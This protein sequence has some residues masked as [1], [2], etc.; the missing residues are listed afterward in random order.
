MVADDLFSKYGPNTVFALLPVGLDARWDG[1]RLRVR[2]WPDVLHTTAH[3]PKLSPEEIDAGQAYWQAE[4]AAAGNDQ[5]RRAAWDEL[6]ER[7]GSGRA[8]WVALSLTPTN[9]GSG[10]PPVF[11]AVETR[12]EDTDPFVPTSEALPERFVL[13]GYLDGKQVFES[14]GEP[15]PKTLVTGLDTRPGEVAG[16]KNKEGDDLQLPAQMRWMSDFDEAK[17]LGLAFDLTIT[18][19]TR[20]DYLVVFGVRGGQ[21]EAA[22]GDLLNGHRF[23]RGLAFVPPGTPTNHAPGEPSGLPDAAARR[24]ISFRVERNK[25]EFSAPGDPADGRLLA[26]ALGF[27]STFFARAPNSGAVAAKIDEPQGFGVST[28]A[29]AVR[30]LWSVTLGGFLEDLV[31]AAPARVESVRTLAEDA[32]RP[33][34]PLPTL[35][36]GRQPYGVLPVLSFDHLAFATEDSVDPSLWGALVAARSVLRQAHASQTYDGT[37]ED[38]MRWLPRPEALAL[39]ALE[40]VPGGAQGNHFAQLAQLVASL[41]GNTL[42]DTWRSAAIN[43]VV[44]AN[45][46]AL[47]LPWV[48]ASLPASL[49]Q[50]STG[51]FFSFSPQVGSL[52]GRIIRQAGSLEWARFARTVIGTLADP[53]TTDKLQKM[54]D[55]P[56]SVGP[57]LWLLAL[58]TAFAGVPPSSLMGTPAAAA[59]KASPDPA[60]G[61]TA[62][63][64]PLLDPESAQLIRTTV[65]SFTIPNPASPGFDRLKRFRDTLTQLGAVPVAQIGAAL[66]DLIDL[67]HHRPDAWLTAIATRRLHTVRAEAPKGVVL[68]AWGLLQ[69]VKPRLR[70]PVEHFWAPSADQAATAAVLRAGGR[71]LGGTSLQ[72]DLPARRART[73]LAL[74]E[75]VRAGYAPAFLLGTATEARLF[76]HDALRHELR[77]QFPAAPAGAF[78]DGVALSTA[79]TAVLNA[80]RAAFPASVAAFNGAL[81]E[82]ANDVDAIADAL[83][84]ES[85]HRVA[86]GDASAGLFDLARLAEGTSPPTEL[87]SLET[88]VDA[89]ALLLRVGAVVPADAVSAWPTERSARAAADPHVEAWASALLGPPASWAITFGGSDGNG[90]SMNA[91]GFEIAALDLVFADADEL[92]ERARVSLGLAPAADL[93]F[94][95]DRSWLSL[96]GLCAAIRA[97]LSDARALGAHDLDRPGVEP[98][99]APAAVVARLD[100]AAAR[101]TALRDALSG[102]SGG[103]DLVREAALFGLR[104][105]G[106]PWNT[107]ALAPDARQAL[108]LAAD[109]RLA[110]D[111]LAANPAERLRA[112]FA[113]PLPGAGA[114]LAPVE[115]RDTLAPALPP[116]AGTGAA[117]G[118]AWLDGAGRVRPNVARFAELLARVEAEQGTVTIP[119]L[120]QVPY[121]PAD[122]WIATG[123]ARADGKRAIGRAT[124]WLHSPLAI[125]AKAPIAGLRF[126]GW[127]EG[128]PLERPNTAL[129]MRINAPDSRP[130]HVV[131]LAVAPTRKKNWL[132]SHV[133]GS[134]IS[135]LEV[136]RMRVEPPRR[137]ELG[138]LEPLVVLGRTTSGGIS[139]DPNPTPGS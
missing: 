138:G 120:T 3:D 82:L 129:A 35:R 124:T 70:A 58:A 134:I 94:E 96:R 133:G 137:W 102:S 135:A 108:R 47:P 127:S 89:T 28:E 43:T 91:Q 24:E 5:A 75:G 52:A 49:A 6:A 101:L 30:A 11:P 83:L 121:D 86:R 63:P 20:L 104:L 110:A 19:V 76:G 54:V 92:A 34:G 64:Q 115:A 122:P 33:A 45:P 36:V 78:V 27:D 4:V 95:P 106:L 55:S 2:V 26:E 80:L 112:L 87:S 32:L 65:G 88:P 77:K 31:G 7:F 128:V 73:A 131:L 37:L 66:R 22:L 69:D 85:V 79:S 61:A 25:R 56:S 57:I 125:D 139:F 16:L 50:W 98:A 18:K 60:P 119:R 72:V 123:F 39:E 71:A 99:P 105:E 84:A 14:I 13:Q 21:G 130:P 93:F 23:T 59:P 12:K 15:L 90:R 117:D 107:L 38:A 9:Q 8:A 29:A 74:L 81:A 46:T 97:A 113:A 100:A 103:A 51:D 136:A 114:F 111:Q 17:R 1:Q 116:F 48:D 126:D 42:P 10:Q 53:K 68:G 132:A 118:M 67:Y 44:E 62:P 41:S 109:A 40:P